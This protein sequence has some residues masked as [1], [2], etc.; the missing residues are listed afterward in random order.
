[1]RRTSH[2][3]LTAVL[4]ASVFLPWFTVS[5]SGQPVATSTGSELVLGSVDLTTLEALATSDPGLARVAGRTAEA[6]VWGR[7]WLALILAL[8][9]IGLAVSLAS[10]RR[11][12]PS[13]TCMLTLQLLMLVVVLPAVPA[14]L[15]RLLATALG[16]EVFGRPV[17]SP[18][19]QAVLAGIRID[20]GSGYWTAAAATLCGLVLSVLRR[21]SVTV[22]PAAQ[23]APVANDDGGAAT[24]LTRAP[25]TAPLPLAGPGLFTTPATISLAY[26]DGS[27]WRQVHRAVLTAGP[28]DLGLLQPELGGILVQCMAGRA[29]ID[30]HWSAPVTLHRGAA[31]T[32]LDPAP[33][34]LVVWPGDVLVAGGVVV[35]VCRR[36]VD[37]RRCSISSCPPAQASGSRIVCYKGDPMHGEWPEWMEYID[38]EV[39]AVCAKHGWK[40]QIRRNRAVLGEPVAKSVCIDNYEW[41][42]ITGR[43]RDG[44]E[45]IL[46][47]DQFGSHM[48]YGTYFVVRYD[49]QQSAF[50]VLHDT[51]RCGIIDDRWLMTTS[52]VICLP[53]EARQRS[54]EQGPSTDRI[55]SA[56][57]LGRVLTEIML[58]FGP[59]HF[60][61][62]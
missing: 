24:T 36:G 37:T 34:R 12:A 44:R 25:S 13:L 42:L 43:D 1:M 17:N 50:I 10:R 48:D 40:R 29:T 28:F 62:T 11:T 8:A 39:E 56:G 7:V 20:A 35:C 58:R 22:L 55:P 47:D 54:G 45:T 46:T 27:A 60:S 6:L 2:T 19:V 32:S 61:A 23:A 59:N 26:H 16:A 30:A 51:N 38:A 31:A 15:P 33:P 57:W 53:L 18:A 5:C 21:R 4:L 3:I 49:S 14:A 52:T 41:K 9:V